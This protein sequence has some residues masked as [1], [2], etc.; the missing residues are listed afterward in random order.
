MNRITRA[1][2][3]AVASLALFT[4]GYVLGHPA[5]TTPTTVEH[6]TTVVQT[7]DDVASYNDGFATSKQDDCEQGFQAACDWPML[8]DDAK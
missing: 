3:V 4:G 2:A 8:P 6:T 7:A 1:I 5:S